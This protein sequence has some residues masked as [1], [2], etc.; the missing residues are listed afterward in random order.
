MSSRA[1]GVPR[2]DSCATRLAGMQRWQGPAAIPA[3]SAPASAS[4]S[5]LAGRS[6]SESHC[7]PATPVPTSRSWTEGA[8]GRA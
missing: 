1:P 3:S 6:D 8:R 4:A 7:G 2:R 5:G